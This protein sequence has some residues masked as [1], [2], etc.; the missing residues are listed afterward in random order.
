MEKNLTDEILRVCQV[1]NKNSVKYLIVGGTAVAF[2][3]YFR[4]S[5]NSTDAPAENLILIFGIIPHMT[6]TLNF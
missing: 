3:G 6:I 2:H 4:W 1:L 5:K